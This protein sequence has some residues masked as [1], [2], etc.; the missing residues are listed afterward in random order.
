MNK[1]IISASILSGLTLLI[2][3]LVGEALF[4]T[5]ALQSNLS[6]ENKMVLSVVW[7]GITSVLALSFVA[8][9]LATRSMHDKNS[10]LIFIAAQLA[11]IAAL[12]VGFG[13]LHESRAVGTG[14]GKIRR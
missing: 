6:I 12:F 3:T 13:L 5:P 14:T 1:W 7:H 8:L 10:L 11:A 2:H 4:H 9:A